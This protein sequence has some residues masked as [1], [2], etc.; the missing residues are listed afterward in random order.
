MNDSHY[1]FRAARWGLLLVLFV[2]LMVVAASATPSAAAAPLR[3]PSPD[4][5]WADV[6]ET[7]FEVQGTR[8]IIPQRY[9]T[10]T[11]QADLLQAHLLAAPMEFT[12]AAENTIAVITLPL[13]DGSYQSF[14]LY[15]SPVMAPELAAKFP[16][17]RTYTAKG[18]DDVYASGRLDW[19]PK[20]FHAM[21][22]SPGATF[23]IDPYSQG[24]ITHYISY[25]KRDFVPAEDALFEELGP[26]DDGMQTPDAVEGGPISGPTLRTHRL[27][28][29]TTGEYSIYHGGTVPLVMAEV[30]TAINRVTGVYEREIGIRLELIPNN[31]EIIYLNPATDPY[32]NNNGSTMLSENQANLDNVIGTANYD[33]G[34]VFSTGGGGVAYLNAVC[35]ST[36]KARGVTG[37]TNP[38]GDPFYIDYVAHEMGHQY[39]GNHTF[40][41]NEGACAGNRN[42]ATAYEPGSG[43]TIQAYAGICGSQNLQSNS[44]DYFHT[45]SFQEMVNF[46]TVGGG[47][48]CGTTISTGNNP[49]VVTVPAGGF[50]IPMDTP[51]E[52]TGSADDP[53]GD[54]LTYAWEEFDLGPPGHPNSPVGNAPIFRSF[55]PVTTPTRT[56]PKMSD[57]VNNTQTIGEKLP[58]YARNLTFRLTARDNFVSPSAGGVSFA[59]VNFAVTADAGPFVV[60]S[61]NSNITW[62]ID[63]MQ[64]VTWD[65]ANT[66]VAP[67]NCTDVNILLSTDGGYTYPITLASSVPNTGSYPVVVP[68]NPTTTAR[69]QVRC[70]NNIFFD[71]SNANF[72]IANVTPYAE[73]SI[74]KTVEP[75]GEVAPGDTLT[76]TIVVTNSGN[77]DATT[78]ISD[79]FSSAL[80]NPVCDGVPGDLLITEDLAGPSV[81]SYECVA[82]VASDIGV[83]I[84]KSVDQSEVEAGTAVTYTIE[85]SNPHDSVTLENVV[86]EDAGVNGCTPALDTPITLGPGESETYVCPNNVIEEDTTNTA[87]ATGVAVITNVAS[88]ESDEDP[89]TPITTDEVES[90]V[91]VEASASATVTIGDGTT[92]YMLYLPAVVSTAAEAAEAAQPY[93]LPTSLTFALAGAAVIFTNRRKS[94]K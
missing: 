41:G 42:G 18:I 40:N 32:T 3:N 6:E 72:T 20:G 31:D 93:L 36:T 80:V 8:L 14:R 82:Q 57:I 66:N 51:F 34:H 38:I 35:S 50:T 78:T 2:A 5:I 45:I 47:S 22:Y 15:E 71:I 25:Y 62:G 24:D 75:A 49:P 16:T 19:T 91:A 46:T 4:G 43:S 1:S 92:G 10:V 89:S 73:L 64:T 27:A 9:R 74:G 30:V 63:T 52:L 48:T 77:L 87:T 59:Q 65:V 84:N 86:V 17:I 55:D 58:T 12:Q 26:I 76:Y 44:D 69:V 7:S 85:V 56:F 21:I 79:E 88:A 23:Y 81:N 60:T 53:D 67:V 54:P 28:V 61:P 70:A 29:A 94:G 37:L 33:V 68:N 39:G 90:L 83:V 13:P 11:A